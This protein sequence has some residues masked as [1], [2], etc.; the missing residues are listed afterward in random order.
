MLGTVLINIG[1]KQNKIYKKLI[2]LIRHW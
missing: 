1:Q 2:Q